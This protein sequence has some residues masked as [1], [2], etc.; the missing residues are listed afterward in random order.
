[1]QR[2]TQAVGSDEELDAL[3]ALLHAPLPVSFRLNLH[4]PDA[5]RLKHA[6]ATSLQFPPDAHF[7]AGVA[8]NP[9]AYAAHVASVERALDPL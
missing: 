5:E 8:V 2:E 3:M 6:L 4:R 7:H 1:L 9:P